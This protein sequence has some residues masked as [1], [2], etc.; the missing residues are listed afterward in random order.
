MWIKICGILTLKAALCSIEAGVDAIGFVF[1][2]SRRKIDI[3]KAAN[4]IKALPSGIEKVG[5]FVDMPHAEVKAIAESLGLN[6]L[7]FHGEES[8]EYCRL[9]PGKAIKSFAV[10]DP[11]D[12]LAIEPYRNNISACLLDTFQEG[13]PG[14]TG[15]AWNWACLAGKIEQVLDGIPLIVAGGLNARNV[16]EAITVLKPYGV[17]ISSGVEKAGKKDCQL[18][19]E[20]I[21]E[22]RR[23]ENAQLA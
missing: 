20:F 15:N 7:Q 16:G 2:D 10:K 5:V 1:A 11:A 13:R 4:I 17:D 12:L 14:G 9:F 23:W 22:A 18:I 8:P 19:K 21:E 6:L 3:E